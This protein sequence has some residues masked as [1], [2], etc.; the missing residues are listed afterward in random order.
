MPQRS[1]LYTL[2][3]TLIA[4]ALSAQAF[5]ADTLIADFE[6]G[7]DDKSL[8]FETR[9]ATAEVV[10]TDDGHA[11]VVTLGTEWK[12]PNVRFRGRWDLSAHTHLLADVTNLSPESIK[13]A[14]RLDSRGSHTGKVGNS[15]SLDP[16]DTVTVRIPLSRPA[17]EGYEFFDDLEGMDVSPLGNRGQNAIDPSHV[18]SI[19][20]FGL[21]PARPQTFRVD[22]IRGSGTFIP[23]ADLPAP[24]DFF[25]ILDQFGQYRHADWPTKVHSVEEFAAAIEAERQDLTDNPPPSAWDEL[26]GW[27]DGPTLEADGTWRTTKRDGRWWL[28]TPQ[29][30]LFWSLGVDV[31]QPG[32]STRIGPGRDGWFDPTPL[33]DPRFA[34]QRTVTK[35]ARGP[36]AG[37]DQEL[38]FYYNAN[39]IRKFGNNWERSFADLAHERLPSWGFNTIGNW[40]KGPVIEN[41]P[42][43]Y[44]HWIFY[45]SPRIK[46]WGPNLPKWFPD[47]YHEGF[48]ENLDNYAT[49]FLRGHRDDPMLIGVFVDN[50]LPWGNETKM[51]ELAIL[52]PADTPHAKAFVD[53]LQKQHGP[54]IAALNA[55]WGT[56]YASWEAFGE[57]KDIPAGE[58]VTRDM[59]GFSE[60]TMRIYFAA[61]RDAVRKHAPGK[62]YLGCRFQEVQ[63]N[64][65]V[66]RISAEYS[67]VVSFNVYREAVAQWQPPAD[68]DKPVLIGEWHFGAP[69]RG[70]WGSGL[71]GVA[72]QAERAD[73]VRRYVGGAL[74]NP[75]LV[76]AHWFQYIDQPTTGRPLDEE[77]HQIGLVT[78]ADVPHYETIEA[79]REMG[80][81]MYEVRS[82]P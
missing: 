25:P 14:A 74:T 53:Y 81:S 60:Q 11:M 36:N 12:W 33:E 43:P 42:M 32:G 26:G 75:L 9:D 51:A 66:T 15:F 18:F 70:I 62:L 80:A 38:F 22:N 17:P 69:D 56:S 10:A 37:K 39:L 35:T 71:V 72:N 57:S 41:P 65:L 54:D 63:V 7:P 78:I 1:S 19:Q 64:P 27:A 73:A 21:T 76:G 20:F 82:Q 6:A 30:K 79:F 24:D 58:T 68:I 49:R 2:V 5:A 16:N 61:A 31:V 40:A 34:N 29:G 59:L 47:V 55:A 44:T 4:T 45:K 46:V 13:I 50:E 48:K 67:D 28:V 8:T 23:P 77:N 52:A 3:L